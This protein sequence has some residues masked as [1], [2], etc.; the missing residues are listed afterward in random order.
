VSTAYDRVVILLNLFD[1]GYEAGDITLDGEVNFRDVLTIQK[2]LF[3]F[4]QVP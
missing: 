4:S 2:H 3:Q 1:N